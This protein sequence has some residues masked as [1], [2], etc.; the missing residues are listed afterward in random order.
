MG[1]FKHTK[2]SLNPTS[3][4]RQCPPCPRRVHPCSQTDCYL[5][6]HS[7]LV[8]SF[9]LRCLIHPAIQPDC[10]TYGGTVRH[11]LY[12]QLVVYPP[13][14]G[15]VLMSSNRRGSTLLK[16]LS[17]LTSREGT[18]MKTCRARNGKG[19]AVGKE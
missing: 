8:L 18:I 14:A 10:H 12:K 5:P 19:A 11:D 16:E 2:H 17:R 3:R 15:P 1:C 4:G 7:H 13:L 9:A 6:R